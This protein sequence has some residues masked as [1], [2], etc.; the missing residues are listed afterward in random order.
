MKNVMNVL[1]LFSIYC[2][3]HSIS[4][5]I[6]STDCQNMY[7]NKTTNKPCIEP[8]SCC[9]YSYI[10]NNQTNYFCEIIPSE[11]ND[12]CERYDKIIKYTIEAKDFKCYCECFLNIPIFHFLAT[13]IFIIYLS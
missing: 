4:T 3:S 8:T 1:F 2:I 7:M 6:N 9:L 11:N 10:I 13:L 12:I 5:V